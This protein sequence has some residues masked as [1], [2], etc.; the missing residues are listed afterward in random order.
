VLM[1]TGT[2]FIM[3]LGEQITERGIGNGISL[4]IFS[5]IVADLPDALTQTWQQITIGQIQPVHLLM[6][7]AIAFAIIG[8]IVFFERGQR[9]IPIMY[10]RRSVG[11]RMETAPA[12]T[13]HLPLRVNG[14]GVIP[15]IFASSLLMFPQTLA[16]LNVPGAQALQDMLAPGTWQFNFV[17]IGL[18]IFFAFFYTAV[19]F[20]PV[21]LADS[22]KKQNAFIPQVRPGK[23]TAEFIDYV[24][25]R[26]TVGGAMYMAA[27]C[28]VPTLLQA[29]FHVPFF[30]GGT[31]V[32]IVVGVA[33]DTV[34]QIESHLITRH[35]EGLTGPGGPR[36]RGRRG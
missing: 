32:M 26:I 1:T 21:E 7:V 31:S 33:L 34:Q 20:Q 22:L 8:V 9:R 4:I 23:A 6:V 13:Q 10:A 18:I 28:L 16:N 25:T 19:T 36:I 3:W 35:Y 17:Y 30:F 15:P 27:V 12:A 2:A 11:R 14:A 24:V 5:G 29:W